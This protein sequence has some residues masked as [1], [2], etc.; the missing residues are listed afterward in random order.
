MRMEKRF[1]I[2][3]DAAPASEHRQV[4][5]TFYKR[6]TDFCGLVEVERGRSSRNWNQ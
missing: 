4:W 1:I 6:Q 3:D 2:Q 5:Q